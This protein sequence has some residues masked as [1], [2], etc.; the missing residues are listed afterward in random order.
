M[1]KLY[2]LINLKICYIVLNLLKRLTQ[3]RAVILLICLLLIACNKTVQKKSEITRIELATGD[4]F[5]PCQLTSIRIDSSLKYQFYGGWAPD[6]DPT[7]PIHR[8]FTKGYYNG[9]LSKPLWDTLT[10]HLRKINYRK[11]DTCYDHSADDQSLELIIHYSNKVKHIKAQSASLPSE[12][13]TV[14]Y[15]IANSYKSIKLNATKQPIKFET[16]YQQKHMLKISNS[17]VL[18]KKLNTFLCEYN[19]DGQKINGQGIQCAFAEKEHTINDYD[20]CDV[21]S[22]ESQFVIVFKPTILND[23][24]FED[25]QDGWSL[26]VDSSELSQS[27]KYVLI[28]KKR[29]LF[30]PDKIQLICTSNL[31]RHDYSLLTANIKENYKKPPITTKIILRKVN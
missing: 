22:T 12:V 25:Y 14:F 11:L 17:V 3:T 4:C 16:I 31:K 20:T 1:N 26:S 8:N 29:A 24:I 10:A 18:A 9:R 21:N 7:V 5:G 2:P 28:C 19:V 27:D 23:R 15:E 30:Y 13:R 6:P